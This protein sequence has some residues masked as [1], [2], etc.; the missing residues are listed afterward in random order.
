VTATAAQLPRRRTVAYALPNAS[1]LLRRLLSFTVAAIG[2]LLVAPLIALIAIAIKLTSPGPVLYTQTRIGINRRR[3]LPAGNN[4]RETDRGGKPFTIYKFRTMIPNGH[5]PATPSEV[6]ATPDDPRVT[7]LGRIL[8]LYRLDE[9]PQLLNVLLGD[10]DIV[11]PRPEQP[12]IFARLRREIDQY[13]E[14]QRVRPGITGWAQV[15][16]QYDRSIE[17]VKKKL[18][19]DLEYI[20]NKS[21]SHDLEIM[22]RTF[23]VVTRKQGAW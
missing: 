9:L 5:G 6:W 10:M 2:I 8:R 21:V 22:V 15:N 13:Q 4:Y 20:Q 14:R 3:R 16:Q 11:G 17:D 7:K 18:Q 12:S 1:D 23:G 19:F